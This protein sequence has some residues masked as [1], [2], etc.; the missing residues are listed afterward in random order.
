MQLGFLGTGRL[1]VP[2]IENLV[3]DGHAVTA[4]NRTAARAAPLAAAGVRVVESPA[5]VCAAGGMVLSCLADDTALDAV[6]ADGAVLAALGPGGVHVSMSTI[7]AA[8][9]G[10][11][12]AAH[13]AAGV[14]YLGAPV[15]GRPDAVAGRL[16]SYLLAGAPAAKARVEPVLAALGRRVFDFGTDPA[17]ANV[18]KI[19]FNFLIAGAIEAMAEAF[20]VVEKAGLDPG[21]FYEMVV[22]SAFGCPLYQNYGRIL[23][24]QGWDT[25]A[26]TL[27]LGLKD[28]RLAAETAAE[29]DARMRLGELLE[30]RFA[31]AVDHGLG[32]KD[33]TAVAV[34]VRAE[35]GLGGGR[36]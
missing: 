9:A 20:A 35:A 29:C 28:V 34:D 10:R 16:Q 17:A 19:N 31:A 26:F 25:P 13:A 32:E 24:E 27:A 15:I 7:S 22:G 2:M 18:A 23:V 5:A 11:L 1:S 12:A 3:A 36:D 8:C 21:T 6:F 14:D 30:R 4:W 33:W